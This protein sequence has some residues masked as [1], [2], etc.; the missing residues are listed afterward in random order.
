MGE[1][2]K[3]RFEGMGR[4]EGKV[5]L[6]S[7]GAGG[8]GVAQ[9]KLLAKERAKVVFGDIMDDAGKK[10]EEMI[11]AADGVATYIHLDV[12]KEEDWRRAVDS[13]VSRYVKL[14][15]LVNTAGVID[16]VGIENATEQE[17]DK[18]MNV[19]AKGVFLGIKHAIPAMRKA[20]GGSIINISSIAALS[21]HDNS[22][23]AYA[24]SKGAVRSFTKL[25]SVQHARD[26]IRCN[27]IFPGPIDTPMLHAFQQNLHS[28]YDVPLGRIGTPEDIAYAVVYLAS[29]EAAFITGAELTIDGGITSR[30]RYR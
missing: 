3:R 14:D 1:Y 11:R 25:V 15:I 24:A 29:D 17:W 4:L 7:G 16:K 9:V 20:G 27:C 23:P 10:V 18:V 26:G 8:I 19:N 13:A 2:R 12:A 22:L 5:A 28:M 21:A 30:G 6:V